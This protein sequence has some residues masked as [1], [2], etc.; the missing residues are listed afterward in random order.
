[1]V[2]TL[3]P[4]PFAQERSTQQPWIA[5]KLVEQLVYG[6]ASLLELDDNM[7]DARAVQ[8]TNMTHAQLIQLLVTHSRSLEHSKL[9]HNSP[10][11]DLTSLCLAAEAGGD[12]SFQN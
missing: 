10:I 9:V 8:N 6:L 2:P 11:K 4:I 12:T 3:T 1:M 7:S 5:R